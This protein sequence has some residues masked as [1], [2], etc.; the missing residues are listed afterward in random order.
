MND[1]YEV[2]KQSNSNTGKHRYILVRRGYE[3]TNGYPKVVA[4]RT[5]FFAQSKANELNNDGAWVVAVEEGWKIRDEINERGA[6]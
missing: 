1:R 4:W 2:V 6:E 5:R 3:W